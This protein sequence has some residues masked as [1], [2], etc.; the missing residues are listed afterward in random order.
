MGFIVTTIVGILINLF[1][2]QIIQ[3]KK[4]IRKDIKT[5]KITIDD[6]ILNQK[7]GVSIKNLFKKSVTN[8][9]EKKYNLKEFSVESGEKKPN[10]S[11]NYSIEEYSVNEI[12]E[13]KDYNL[14]NYKFSLN[15]NILDSKKSIK[16]KRI[17]FE[18]KKS[19]SKELEKIIQNVAEIQIN[20]FVD[21]Y[22]IVE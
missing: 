5:F 7:L 16:E 13:K 19:E 18:M 11:L 1:Y 9:L 10:L 17:E 8:L 2:S 3:T 15:F 20:E 12:K 14:V 22:L 6:S 21:N 4:T